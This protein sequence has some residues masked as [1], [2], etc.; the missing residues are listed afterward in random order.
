MGEEMRF[1]QTLVGVGHLS[2]MSDTHPQNR[3]CP[4]PNRYFNETLK[5]R[6]DQV[7]INKLIKSSF[8][9]R[10][11]QAHPLSDTSDKCPTSKSNQQ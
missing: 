7:N 5:N 2:D 6:V 8:M 3:G 4:L 11:R 1:Q 9:T 10:A